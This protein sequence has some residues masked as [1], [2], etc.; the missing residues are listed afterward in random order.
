RGI[1]S[2]DLEADYT[3][4]NEGHAT[5]VTYPTSQHSVNNF[6]VPM[7]VSDP[8][9]TYSYSYDSMGRLNTM[10]QT[11]GPLYQGNQNPPVNFVQNVSYGAAGELLQ[12]GGNGNAG[13]GGESRTYNSLFQLTSI[14]QSDPADYT[15]MSW[16]RMQYTYPDG[17]NTGKISMQTNLTSG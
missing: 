13:Y 1:G 15:G 10:A 14:V 16:L 8:G 11:G 3:Y 12:I 5:S 4:D 2:T 17:A 7:L 6:G 9:P